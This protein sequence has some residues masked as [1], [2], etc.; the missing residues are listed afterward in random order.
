MA[1]H[2]DLERMIRDTR[3]LRIKDAWSV[4]MQ[5]RV[6][7]HNAQMRLNLDVKAHN[8]AARKTQTRRETPR[9]PL[10]RKK[11]RAFPPPPRT[12]NPLSD[13]NSRRFGCVRVSRGTS[14]QFAC[15]SFSDA[16]KAFSTS[17]VRITTS[18]L[19]QNRVSIRSSFNIMYDHRGHV[20]DAD[21]VVFRVHGPVLHGAGPKDAI[22]TD[23]RNFIYSHM[24]D[25]YIRIMAQMRRHLGGDAAEIDGVLSESFS[26]DIDVVLDVPPC[27]TMATRLDGASVA[28]MTVGRLCQEFGVERKLPTRKDVRVSDDAAGHNSESSSDSSDS[29]S[30]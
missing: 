11:H 1:A 25:L 16:P 30:E 14:V 29:E 20:T 21:N 12:I 2:P 4:S 3:T 9:N 8:A 19:A 28:L 15:T 24:F 7:P 23:A 17:S 13:P 18:A 26:A 6:L 27:L 5:H 22:M 10:F